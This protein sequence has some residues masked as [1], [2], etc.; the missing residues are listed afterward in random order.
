MNDYEWID[1]DDSDVV[2]PPEPEV[3][4]SFK[5]PVYLGNRFFNLEEDSEEKTPY[6]NLG[7][8]SNVIY[9]AIPRSCTCDIT[10]PYGL[11]GVDYASS[12][13]KMPIRVLSVHQ[14]LDWIISYNGGYF[15][16]SVITVKVYI[17]ESMRNSWDISTLKII[18]LDSF[19]V[20]DSSWLY[21]V[22]GRIL[23]EFTRLHLFYDQ[24]MG[25]FEDDEDHDRH[26]SFW[27]SLDNLSKSITPVNGID[28]LITL[29]KRIYTYIKNILTTVEYSH[30]GKFVQNELLVKQNDYH[31]TSEPLRGI[32]KEDGKV[33]DRDLLFALP[34]SSSLQEMSLEEFIHENEEYNGSDNWFESFF[35]QDNDFAVSHD[36]FIITVQ[37]HDRNHI[38]LQ[39]Y[40]EKIY[41]LYGCDNYY[42]PRV[43]QSLYNRNRKD[44]RQK[45][46]LP[47]GLPTINCAIECID[48]L[49]PKLGV[50]SNPKITPYMLRKISRSDL[51]DIS[52]LIDLKIHLIEVIKSKAKG[53]EHELSREVIGEGSNEIV[54]VGY[55]NSDLSYHCIG[56][57]G[58]WYKIGNRFICESCHKW[59]PNK[60]REE[61]VNN[62][63]IC[64]VCGL[65]CLMNSSHWMTCNRLKMLPNATPTNIMLEPVVPDN[66]NLNL[67]QWFCDI[68]A[69]PDSEND[70]IHTCY[71]IVIKSLKGNFIS[72]YGK[73][74]LKDL[75]QFLL[76]KEVHGYLWFHNGSGYDFNFIVKQLCMS[77]LKGDI[78]LLKR[79]NRILT[80]TIKKNPSL[81]LRDMYL[82]L[83]SSLR[84]LCA[85]FKI[86]TDKS[87]T[88]FDHSKIK[89]WQ[90]CETHKKE[91]I[92]YCTRDVLALETIYIKFSG[93]LWEICNINMCDSISLTA[94]AM[95]CWKALETPQITSKIIIPES[96]NMYNVFRKMYF[97]GRVLA[98]R[99]A[100]ESILWSY[101]TPDRF[102]ENGYFNHNDLVDVCDDDLKMLDVVSLYP[103]MMNKHKFPVG[104][105]K[106]IEI[107]AIKSTQLI[108][109]YNL[110]TTLKSKNHH[111]ITIKEEMFRSCYNVTITPPKNIYIAFLM[112]K[113][114]S[115]SKNSQTLYCKQKTWYTGV[116][117]Y[118]A[119][120]LGYE[121]NRIYEVIEWP[122]SEHI[123]KKFI[124][125]MFKVKEANKH[126]KSSALYLAAKNCMNGVSGKFGQ[127]IITKTSKLMKELPNNPEVSWN[128]LD[129]PYIETIIQ[130]GQNIGHLMT[131]DRKREE[132]KP[133]HPTHIS[134]FILAYAR[135]HM[136]KIMRSINGYRNPDT[137]LLYTDTDSLI[138]TREAYSKIPQKYLGKELGQLE[139]EYPNDKIISARFLAPKTYCLGIL[140]KTPHGYSLAYKVRCKGIPH[141][142]NTFEVRNL[143]K[144][145]LVSNILNQVAE[146]PKDLSL[147]HY[148]IHDPDMEPENDPNAEAIPSLGIPI[149]DLVLREKY[150][151]TAY[152]GT[153]KKIKTDK[154]QL[155]SL[156]TVWAHRSLSVNN[157]W[158][159]PSC[160]RE[161]KSPF[162][163][164]NITLC[165]G[166]EIPN[167]QPTITE[168]LI[169]KDESIDELLKEMFW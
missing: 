159:S 47:K 91:V 14:Y 118:E 60:K 34:L 139:D 122:L 164:Y 29:R 126:D 107:D 131:A 52:G 158:R 113:I 36:G 73:N 80:C 157:W 78:Q 105:P 37:Y 59:I 85:D 46:I 11:V 50:F 4:P 153:I 1:I 111:L 95:R 23:V 62:C 148:V 145:L 18:F 162:S 22:L 96:L 103:S 27:I 140:K 89:S 130:E 152:F 64:E 86:D 17:N 54:I 168:P 136:S 167:E 114:A 71:C 9:N 119:V 65:A 101:L 124:D 70:S 155:F 154:N 141:I 115:S 10:L 3:L 7:R 49:V 128:N 44:A 150:A 147:R 169:N 82:F 13:L 138:L 129:N 2:P 88:D 53:A 69:F 99:M 143:P 5:R 42:V 94:H 67:D 144:P 30:V 156:K 163:N 26:A 123:F 98:T 72:F 127:K 133:S 33:L 102:N 84:R 35:E 112:E 56:Y 77:G 87:K 79:G 19:M 39:F 55:Q 93:A 16:P 43:V 28:K 142:G 41:P 24:F 8:V 106:W 121:I 25:M 125:K 151:V 146:D 40:S 21:F 137:C 109:R 120:K 6:Y 57:K 132:L 63:I 81:D 61:H 135:R 48:K 12:P 83:P 161:F 75:L 32:T 116:E 160:S 68:E 110:I 97:G 149:F 20:L 66:N 51:K 108:V 165:L 15:K 104:K 166:Q 117:L 90:D 31:A 134:V 58:Q 92:E 45:W 38:P 100:Y 76:S 74:C